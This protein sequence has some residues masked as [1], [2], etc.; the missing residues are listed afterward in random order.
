M[1]SEP[2]RPIGRFTA[3]LTLITV[4]AGLLASTLGFVKD[5]LLL[6]RLWPL[7][8]ISF[9]AEILVARWQGARTRFDWGGGILLLLF[10]LLLSSGAVA[11]HV[12][13]GGGLPRGLL[14]AGSK[15]AEDEVTF[16]LTPAIKQV[17]L[18]SHAGTIELKGTSSD[19]VKVEATFW[20]NAQGTESP[21]LRL[22]AEGETL[23]IGLNEG[24]WSNVAASYQVE[25]PAGLKVDVNSDS[26]RI[27]ANKVL[28][29]LSITN[30]SGAVYVQEGEGQLDLTTQSGLIE[31]SEQR[32]SMKIDAHSGAIR[33]KGVS[34]AVEAKTLSGIITVDLKAGLGAQVE[35]MTDTGLIRGPQ[36]L[37]VQ[38]DVHTG[39]RL[40]AGRVGDGRV[41]LSLSAHSGSIT[42]AQP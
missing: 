29:D 36:W 6:F 9:G 41:A 28:G 22:L 27:Q 16:A 32:G 7:L 38:N 19:E 25:V 20:G 35:A 10:I 13:D 26:G 18:E 1:Q 42:I 21:R 14:F 4:G 2:R 31:V 23:V 39:K 3:A 37:Q 11:T 30:H 33:L 17:R 5:W 15:Q 40:A 34:G 12:I 8:L 24:D